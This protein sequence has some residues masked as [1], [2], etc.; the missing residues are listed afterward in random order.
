M[1]NIDQSCV[2]LCPDLV[3][4]DVITA[5]NI[6]IDTHMPLVT[7]SRKRSRFIKSLGLLK[8]GIQ[9]LIH[10][11]D[12]H[13]KYLQNKNEQNFTIYKTY[14]NKLTHLKDLSRQN[15]DKHLLIVSE[16]KSSKIW[17]V[18]NQLLGQNKRSISS[19]VSPLKIDE[20]LPTDSKDISNAFAHHFSNVGINISKRIA[21]TNLHY[22]ETFLKNLPNSV[23]SEDTTPD[24]ILTKIRG[25]NNRKIVKI[26]SVITTIFLLSF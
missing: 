7:L 10:R 4:K 1:D 9:I 20:K 26:L 13:K 19:K 25:L 12:K 5:S 6:V 2:S 8:K 21:T 18:I 11:R 16:G 14:R 22:N 24:E 17:S 3:S 23:L 15:Y